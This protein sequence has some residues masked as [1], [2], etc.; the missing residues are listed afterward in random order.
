MILYVNVVFCSLSKQPK[1]I[2]NLYCDVKHSGFALNG[3]TQI[4]GMAL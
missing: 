1:T 4:T 3:V 2:I